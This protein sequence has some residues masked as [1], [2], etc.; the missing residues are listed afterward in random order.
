[1]EAVALFEHTTVLLEETVDLVA[2]RDG[3]RY[4]DCTLGGGGHSERLL[5][6]SAPSGRVLGIDQDPAAIRH[7]GERLARYGERFTPVHG[8]FRDVARIAVE[9]GF[10]G[11]DGVVFDLGVSSVQLD[12][13]ERGF[14]YRFD[15]PLDM[16][17]NPDQPKSAADLVN[18]LS[19]PE[20]A[21]LI[22]RFGEERFSRRIARAIVER[23]KRGR[24]ESTA[25]LAELVK[26]A[27][28]APARRTGPHPA[29]RTFQALRIAVND[30]LGALEAALAG[31]FET[32]RSGGRIAVITFHSLEDR[33]VKKTFAGWAAG[34]V[35]PP[36][37]P[38]CQCGRIPQARLLVKK[39]VT[40]GAAELARNP[41]ARSAKLRAI[42]K[43]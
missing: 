5:E 26:S 6:R 33:I 17:M 22:F 10:T 25:E 28:P 41:R 18:E 15:A 11:A 27:I 16:R 35:C 3:G 36:E 7:A 8:N 42:E 4:I 37:L 39:P 2:P 14:S 20:L 43:L 24:I 30:E 29:R 13:A 38:V 32:V 1:M 31:A 34:C 9:F 23:R 40:P 19:E 21:D 12:E